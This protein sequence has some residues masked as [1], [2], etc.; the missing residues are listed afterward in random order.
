MGIVLNDG[1]RLPIVR[2]EKL[3]FAADTP[4]ETVFE[5]QSYSKELWNLW[6]LPL[7]GDRKPWAFLETDSRNGQFSPDG[8]WIAYQSTEAG[9]DE[10]Y[11]RPFPS[12]D[13]RGRFLSQAAA[14]LDG[15][16]TARNCI[17]SRRM[18]SSWQV[19]LRSRAARRIP[20]Y[21]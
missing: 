8:N 20:A 9:P 19:R 15:V 13:R 5:A 3:R 17:T 6:V 18:E 4:Y 1:I 16:Q 21:R 14:S 12:S 2:V 7:D 10:V 11:T